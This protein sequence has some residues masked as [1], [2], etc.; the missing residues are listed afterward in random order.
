MIKIEA[1]LATKRVSLPIIGVDLILKHS[2][3]LKFFFIHLGP[4]GMGPIP[5]YSTLPYSFVLT[6]ADAVMRM[7]QP[8]YTSGWLSHWAQ[9]SHSAVLLVRSFSSGFK[10]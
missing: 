7:P 9:G 3:G 6:P 5:L 1:L 10:M 4:K 2:A 8:A